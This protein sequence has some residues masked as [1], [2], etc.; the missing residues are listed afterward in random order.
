MHF[1]TRHKVSSNRSNADTGWLGRPQRGR[2]RSVAVRRA[3]PDEEPRPTKNSSLRTHYEENIR[4]DST[5]R[6]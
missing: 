5:T 4:A 3:R 2:S 6:D 1:S